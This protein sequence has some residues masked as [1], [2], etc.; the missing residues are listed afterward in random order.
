MDAS[1]L[2][3]IAADPESAQRALRAVA[4]DVVTLGKAKAKVTVDVAT[5]KARAEVRSFK[6]DLASIRNKDVVVNLEVRGLEALERVRARMRGMQK[7]M[8]GFSLRGFATSFRGILT[9][10]PLVVA[11]LSGIAA[12]AGSLAYALAGAA[13]AIAAA[14]GSLGAGL[15]GAA[16][17]GAAGLSALILSFI[18]LRA[19]MAPATADMQAAQTAFTALSDARR[20]YGAGSDQAQA[21]AAKY[22]ETLRNMDPAAAKAVGA[23]NKLRESFQQATGP[24]RREMFGLMADGL[25][26]AQQLMPT[27]AAA[28]NRVAAA[29]H[30]AGRRFF[31]AF[32]VG[33]MRSALNAIM[34]NFAKALPALG[35][36]L[37]NIAKGFSNIAASASRSFEPIATSIAKWARGFAEATSNSS[38]LDATIDTL[39]SHAR[40]WLNLFGEMGRVVFAFFRAVAP[41]GQNLANGWAQS[42]KGL[43]GSINS[44]GAAI[45]QTIRGLLDHTNSWLNLFKQLS[46]IVLGFFKAA[47]PAG[48]GLVDSLAEGAS[49]LADWVESAK[50]TAAIQDFL[51][52][53]R[54]TL[55]SLASLFAKLVPLATQW[56][57]LLAPLIP[58]LLDLLGTL[59]DFLTNVLEALNKLPGPV[60][61]VV[62]AFLLFKGPI[63]TITTLARLL[64]GG[65]LLGAL[66]GLGG[67]AGTAA[68]GIGSLGTSLASRALP[69]LSRLGP[70]LGRALPLLT[71]F[72]VVAGTAYTA[73]E[74]LRDP[75]GSWEKAKEG[76]TTLWGLAKSFLGVH[77]ATKVATLD[78]KTAASSVTG[79]ALAA[80][81]TARHVG[82]LQGSFNFAGA[83]ASRFTT[84]LAVQMRG[85]L[86]GATTS[87]KQFSSAFGEAFRKNGDALGEFVR[88]QTTS[89][90]K[91][92]N[93]MR[94][95]GL[96]MTGGLTSALK[97]GKAKAQDAGRE[98]AFAAVQGARVGQ[99]LR[100]VGEMVGRLFSTGVQSAKR[101]AAA[102][103]NAIATAARSSA[104][105]TGRALSGVGRVVGNLFANGVSSAKGA[106][107]NAGKSLAAAA[108]SEVKSVG[109]AMV[110]AGQAVGELFA[111]GIKNSTSS[112]V[113]A[114]RDLAAAVKNVVPNSEP[115][116]PRSPLRGLVRSGEMTVKMFSKGVRNA[117][118]EAAQ[119]LREGL[120]G[121]VKKI[122]P[123]KIIDALKAAMSK[124]GDK[125]AKLGGL[126]S[127]LGGAIQRIFAEGQTGFS[128]GAV[129]SGDLAGSITSGLPIEDWLRGLTGDIQSDMNRVLGSLANTAAVAQ[130]PKAGLP[131]RRGGGDSIHHYGGINVAAPSTGGPADPRIVAANLDL[132]LRRRGKA[133]R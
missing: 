97:Q 33:S 116:D 32:D 25:K 133:H 106:A 26:R 43:A 52:R 114:A 121:G 53:M 71:R 55:D 1:L 89:L 100:G 60:K 85:A 67:L 102:A 92:G 6:A 88:S 36:A 40:T 20:K 24:T 44:N 109:G 117:S 50:G 2:I 48:K 57:D 122:D 108:S 119:A 34:G 81:K 113:S 7:S 21:A 115:K 64:G 101:G 80:A 27:F 95:V 4:R 17:V 104:Q 86:G 75:A 93:M 72:S 128:G 91:A 78:L 83:S 74:I 77:E 73:Y 13:G 19:A 16:A 15:A 54:P 129:K 49:R 59:V 5:T 123:R 38:K 84:E 22:N 47:A 76:A 87:V 41:L 107:A 29:L 8:K 120:G 70:L 110:G 112:A 131:D 12:M 14:A 79:F 127:D 51:A 61:A 69:A 96:L 63:G 31:E 39:M 82:S 90:N 56:T 125:A 23:L 98:L 42:M 28:T 68:R 94:R 58:P 35:T 126:Q 45:R 111:Q 30:D 118:G 65:G 37:G 132:E 11:A 105:N 9:L 18:G 103:G 99:K 130:G 124:V 66:R 10:S 3:R 46:R 62:A